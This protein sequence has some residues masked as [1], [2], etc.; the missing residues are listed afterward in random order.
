[1]ARSPNEHDI[2]TKHSNKQDSQDDWD[3]EQREPEKKRSGVL[4]VAVSGLALFSDGY[5]AQISKQKIHFGLQA[6]VSE[7]RVN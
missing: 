2:N 7:G 3:L 6:S 5:N 4:N 1:M